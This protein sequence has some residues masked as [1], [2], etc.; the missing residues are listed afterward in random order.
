M[1]TAYLCPSCKTNR[2][3]FNVIEQVATSVKLDPRTGD[4]EETYTSDN[5]HPF[6]K[7]YQGPQRRIQ[8]AACGLVEDEQMFQAFAE[9]HKLT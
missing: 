2:T 3:R 4:V 6:H 1:A 9:H 7:P 8:C 5:V